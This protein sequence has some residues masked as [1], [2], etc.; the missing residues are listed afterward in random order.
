MNTNRKQFIRAVLI[1][2]AIFC[3]SHPWF[4]AVGWHL[5]GDPDAPEVGDYA[6]WPTV[7]EWEWRF[8]DGTSASMRGHLRTIQ[9]IVNELVEANFSLERLVEQNIAN[10]AATSSEEL[11]RY[12]YL[13]GFDPASREYQIMR[14]LP[15]TLIIKAC[16]RDSSD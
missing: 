6:A 14:M 13:T 10:L 9:Q 16:K 1:I 3:L 7:E 2:P 12:P 15:L 5:S 8:E 4:Q 11:A